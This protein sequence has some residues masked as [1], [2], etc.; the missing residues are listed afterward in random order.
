MKLFGII[1]AEIILLLIAILG[2]SCMTTVQTGHVGVVT[3]FGKPQDET[4]EPG[5]SSQ[6]TTTTAKTKRSLKNTSVSHHK[7]SS[8]QT[9]ILL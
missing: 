6:S 5:R 4:L 8:P 2:F 1:G 7:I 9:L 3:L